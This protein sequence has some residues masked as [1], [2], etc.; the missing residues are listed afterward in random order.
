MSAEKYKMICQVA[1]Q[2]SVFEEKFPNAGI[3]EFGIWLYENNRKES[4]KVKAEIKDY[5]KETSFDKSERIEVELSTLITSL[6]RFAKHYIKKA[7]DKTE[8]KTIDEFGFM[9]SLIELGYTTKSE[10]INRHVMEISS[11]SEILKRLIK[12]EMIKEEAAPNDKRSKLISLTPKG[13]M[14]LIKSFGEMQKVARIVNGNLTPD[15]QKQIVYAFNKL[16]Y[17]HEH[18]HE[19]DKNTDLDELMVKYIDN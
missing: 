5:T 12:S 11:G 1:E 17:F 7:L 15:E 14:E 4:K 9:A 18:I 10:L 13:R 3:E 6:F 16:K 8:L 19:I 2:L